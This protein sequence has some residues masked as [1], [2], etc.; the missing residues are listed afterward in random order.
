MTSGAAC[1][2]AV[3]V[4]IVGGKVSLAGREEKGA[5]LLVLALNSC[6]VTS[7]RRRSRLLYLRLRV[8]ISR[9]LRPRRGPLE[10]SGDSWM[11]YGVQRKKV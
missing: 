8:W 11:L 1:A 6:V 3:G 10:D 5:G 9:R 2:K 4:A 7:L